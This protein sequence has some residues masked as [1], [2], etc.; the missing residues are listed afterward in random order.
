MDTSKI[1]SDGTSVRIRNT[2]QYG[3]ILKPVKFPFMG[4]K[5]HTLQGYIIAIDGI[6]RYYRLDELKFDR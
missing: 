3:I 2:T 6:E 4:S 1:Y 5:V